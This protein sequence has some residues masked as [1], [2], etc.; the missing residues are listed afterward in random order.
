MTSD[1]SHVSFC[2]ILV[3]RYSKIVAILVTPMNINLNSTNMIGVYLLISIVGLV[4]PHAAAIDLYVAETGDDTQA[5]TLLK[6]FAT[7]QRARDEIRKMK[8]AG[9]LRTAVSVHVRGGTYWLPQGL[10]LEAQDSGSSAAPIVYRAYQNER[11]VLIGGRR[12][13]GFTPYQGKIVKTDVASQGLNGIAFRQLIFDGRRQHLARHPNFD[14]QNPYGGG[15]AY[16]DGKYI[17]MHQ[18]IPNENRHAF[19]YR[20]ADARVWSKPDQVEVFVFPRFNWWN[21]ICRIQYVNRTTRKVTLAH[22]ASYGIRPGDRYYFRN[23]LEELDAPGEWYL[24]RDTWTLYFWPPAALEGK[25]VLVPTTRTILEL[26]GGTAHVSFRGFILDCA[27]GNAVVLTDTTDCRIVSCT[28]RNVG[29]YY[30]SGVVVQGGLRNGVIGCDVYEVG[31]DAIVLSGG[32]QK[33]LTPAENFADNNYIHHTGVS[34]KQ[35]VGI[36]LSGVGNRVSHNLI[37]DCPRFGILFHGNN[38]LIEYNH[39]RH[40]NLETADTGALYTRGQD[41]LGSRGTVIRYNYIHDSLGYGFENGHWVSP[42]LAWG[43][44]LDDNAGGIDVIGNIIVR[45]NRGLIHLHNG[46]DNRVENNVFVGGKHQQIECNGWTKTHPYWTNSLPEM[47]KAY[48]SV[49]GQPAWRAMRNMHIRPPEAVLPNGMIMTGNT[50]LRNI[51]L[52]L[53]PAAKYVSVTQFPFGQNEWDH[54]LVWHGG[55]PVLTGQLQIGRELSAENLV[56]NGSFEDGRPGTMPRNWEWIGRRLPFLS[57]TAEL[58]REVGAGDQLALRIDAPSTKWKEIAKVPILISKTFDLPLGRYFKLSARMKT[59]EAN[60]KANLMLQ[61]HLENVYFWISAPNEVRV[62]P[63]WKE[64]EFVFKTPAPGD[65]AWHEKMKAFCARIDY[66]GDQGSLF[67]DDIMLKELEVMDEWSAWQ[68]MDMDRNSLV[69]DPLFVD[70]ARDD[71]RLRPE[72][73]AWKL[74]F[75]Q[76]PIEKIGPYRSELRASWPIVE[77]EGVREKPLINGPQ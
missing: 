35:G 41:W 59:S 32:D 7:L 38:L 39:I 25:V 40:V 19:T 53:D 68:A 18:E 44:Y 4:V 51:V 34:Y 31:R 61:S 69:A 66:L 70:P 52:P 5:G 21:N 28:I 22:G 3:S 48:E 9:A 10:K 71:Y 16:A 65:N 64:Y 13:S 11:P 67:V 43:I 1:E 30:G 12:I 45:A 74:G 76:I 49:A 37:H 20:P 62:G 72:S 2:S 23:A 46:R 24:D 17:P 57:A 60:V 42:Q 75:Q 36:H 27:E 15:W 55:R 63:E 29:D 33:T 77:A 6:P 73:P 50:F 54:N 8:K 58:T 14:P 26:M 56:P 47:V